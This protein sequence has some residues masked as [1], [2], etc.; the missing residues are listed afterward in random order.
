MTRK[1]NRRPPLTFVLSRGQDNNG[2]AIF[3]VGC[4]HCHREH[5]LARSLVMVCPITGYA[6]RVV[7]H[8]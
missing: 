8:R 5:Q 2:R 6:M 7:R 1:G 3:R 4:P